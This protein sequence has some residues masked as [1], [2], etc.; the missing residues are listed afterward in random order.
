[1]SY[2]K[3]YWMIPMDFVKV[4]MPIIPKILRVLS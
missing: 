3:N 2:E 4:W 1:M